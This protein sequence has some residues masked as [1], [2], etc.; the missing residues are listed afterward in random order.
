MM[1]PLKDQAVE[2]TVDLNNRR[3]VQILEAAA[4]CFAKKGFN[5]TSVKD[6]AAKVGVTKSMVHYYFDS[7]AHLLHEVLAYY[8]QRHLQRV[9]DQMQVV[10]DS[11]QERS[12]TAL[13]SLWKTIREE[14]RFFRLSLEF[15]A[16]SAHDA[17]LR[18]RLRQ[19]H[20][21]A[22]KLVTVGIEDALGEDKDKLP[23]SNEA[24]GALIMAVLNGM[25]VQEYA[26]PEGVDMDETFRVFLAAMI[27][28]MSMLRMG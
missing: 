23:F 3:V 27:S 21:A 12:R 22:R 24:L 26:E 2:S 5:E 16:I 10:G 11:A 20:E 7:K 15:W 28:S 14:R 1:S 13:K 25:A 6:I 9:T 8:N 4:K 17:K 19:T 18:E